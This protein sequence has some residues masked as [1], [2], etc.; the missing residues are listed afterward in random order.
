MESSEICTLP[1]R[2]KAAFNAAGSEDEVVKEAVADYA[3]EHFEIASYKALVAAAH[4][5]GE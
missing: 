5:L 3:F 1:R 4:E 2:P